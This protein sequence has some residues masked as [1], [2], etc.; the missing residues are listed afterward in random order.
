MAT[1]ILTLEVA[2]RAADRREASTTVFLRFKSARTHPATNG[3][4]ERMG[5]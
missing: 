3:R 2:A 5:R 1:R 4:E